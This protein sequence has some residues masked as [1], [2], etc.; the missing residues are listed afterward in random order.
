M[1]AWTPL[2]IAAAPNGARKTKAD[3]PALPM[4]AADLAE[5]A[6]KCRDAGAAMI[7]MH[8]RDAGGGHLLD[9]DAYNDATAAVRQA[10]GDGV[11][12]QITTEA[13]GVYKPAEQMRVVRDVRP[14]HCSAAVREL[15][16]TESGETD[17]AAFYAWCGAEN[18]RVQH[19][20]YSDKDVERFFALRE[21][22]VIPEVRPFV[23]YVLGR[24]AKGQVSEPSDLLPFLGVDGAMD[25]VWSFCAFGP[26]EGACAA[27][28][29][30]LGGHARVGFE[31]NML[32]ADG[33]AAP[34]NAALVGQA[35]NAAQIIGRPVADAA[36]ARDIL[37]G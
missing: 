2:I 3:H 6:A 12:V 27:M 36:A 10:V 17:A 20:L 1:T 37:E 19:I 7:H 32:M 8:V 22:G 23:L 14:E 16:A 24:Y 28:A 13:A 25:V 18:V 30:S 5:T 11:I 35:S 34:D 15:C 4:T 9:A 21:K 31:N 26:K 29:A 33:S